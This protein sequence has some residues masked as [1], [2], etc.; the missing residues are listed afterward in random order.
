M[1]CDHI[2]V[3]DG[4]KGWLLVE[5]IEPYVRIINVYQKFGENKILNAA[6]SWCS[7]VNTEVSDLP[8]LMT[9]VILLSERKVSYC[10]VRSSAAAF[11]SDD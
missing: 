4:S 8:R 2:T 11:N 1:D 5:P 9:A 7:A 3:I 6:S 10:R